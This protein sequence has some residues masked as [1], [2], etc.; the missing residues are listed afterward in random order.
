MPQ[1]KVLRPFM[2]AKDA[3]ES[4][5]RITDRAIRAMETAHPNQWDEILAD[6]TL[7]M[8]QVF[9][10]K[11]GEAIWQRPRLSG[12]RA[13]RS[14]R[15]ARRERR[16]ATRADRHR[17]QG[18]GSG[19]SAPPEPEPERPTRRRADQARIS[20]HQVPTRRAARG[21][22]GRSRAGDAAAARGRASPPSRA[23]RP[24][25]KRCRSASTRIAS[26]CA[27]EWIRASSCSARRSKTPNVRSALNAEIAREVAGERLRPVGR[28]LRA[29]TQP[30]CAAG[31]GAAERVEGAARG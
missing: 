11:N 5:R 21:A 27:S 30:A 10:A 2:R 22:G 17:G 28:A 18:A 1:D 16:P 7:Q 3:D 26:G 8:K 25:C 29:A 24:A 13:P 4:A 23:L 14:T 31:A 15:G 20:G 6:M 19:A 12:S 9:R